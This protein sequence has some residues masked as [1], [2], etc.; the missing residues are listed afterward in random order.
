MYVRK[1][2]EIS[3]FDPNWPF[4]PSETGRKDFDFS[5]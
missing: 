5:V 4:A 3:V 1:E 2:K